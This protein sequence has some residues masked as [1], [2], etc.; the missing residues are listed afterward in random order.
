MKKL[1][2]I[3]FAAVWLGFFSLPV[4]QTGCSTTPDQRVQTVQTL[5]VVGQSAKTSM[6]TATQLLKQGA[7]TV[8]QWQKVASVYDNSWQPIY[9]VAVNAAHSNLNSV[10]DP[11][12]IGIAAQLAALVA[13]L[14]SK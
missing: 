6:D 8:E 9:S 13:E 1:H 11:E 2:V 10:A 4:L 7:I 3:L 12:L 14:T 5:K